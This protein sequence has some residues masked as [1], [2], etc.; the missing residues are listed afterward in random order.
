MMG[1]S[2]VRTIVTEPKEAS[3]ELAGEIDRLNKGWREKRDS[4]RASRAA[5]GGGSAATAAMAAAATVQAG[6]SKPSS[7]PTGLATAADGGLSAA[8]A[9]GS[10]EG[11]RRILER[12]LTGPNTHGPDG[13]TP[14]CAAAL[15]G[16]ADVVRT[17]LEAAADPGLT[18]LGGTQPTALHMAALQ[19][20][21]K[22]CM[23]LLSAKA[24]PALRDGNGVSPADFA[25]CSEAVW[26][27]FASTGVER[28]SK[29]D[30][31]ARGVIRRA[32]TNLE[33]EL[34]A[35]TD[36]GA[37]NN[38]FG[39]AGTARG[40]LPDF[41]RPGSAYVVSAHHPPRPGS[42]AGYRPPAMGSA[43]PSS[44]AASRPIDILDE[45]EPSGPVG[46]YN[47]GSGKPPT[48]KVFRNEM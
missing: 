21:G 46:G 43:R 28:A 1:I 41:S 2:D 34:Q 33:E 31:V 7:R 39:G 40:V 6:G 47:A 38:T 26:P 45:G 37:A 19:E 17:L 24:D 11:C 9:S 4:F 23:Q 36:G 16:H 12:G 42:S 48:G 22:I 13:T 44:R 20:H 29:E 14:L 18:N 8:A 32:S 30:L 35:D 10:A 5:S 25:A 3:P 15:W 27:L